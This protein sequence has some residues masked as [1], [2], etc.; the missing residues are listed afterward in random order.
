MT[1]THKQFVPVRLGVWVA[2]RA[3]RRRQSSLRRGEVCL[4]SW[5][6]SLF[7]RDKL[8]LR[9]HEEE[10]SR[11]SEGAER[12]STGHKCW[13]RPGGVFKS[14]RD[15]GLLSSNNPMIHCMPVKMTSGYRSIW[16]VSAG[17]KP[18]ADSGLVQIQTELE[19]VE[20]IKS[21]IES[22]T[23]LP[24]PV[25][26]ELNSRLSSSVQ[27]K[28]SKS[29]RCP[30]LRGTTFSSQANNKHP[31]LQ[32]VL[33][34]RAPVSHERDDGACRVTD[35]NSGLTPSSFCCSS[36]RLLLVLLKAASCWQ[37]AEQTVNQF[38]DTWLA[39]HRLWGH[40][41]ALVVTTIQWDISRYRPQKEPRCHD[42]EALKCKQV[43]GE[44]RSKRDTYLTGLKRPHKVKN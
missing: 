7:A 28:G 5:L 14:A 17:F 27:I 20:L 42:V 36:C 25:R 33:A 32:D 41:W 12:S 8:I 6:S 43:C 30:L 19:P 13:S 39:R 31:S 15:V 10:K 1:H 18:K 35:L 40:L 16:T 11:F 2:V 38:R 3:T 26:C 29:G 34:L 4:L 21:N 37:A 23:F 44:I 22:K 24:R 9:R